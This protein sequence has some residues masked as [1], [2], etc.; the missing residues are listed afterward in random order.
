MRKCGFNVL[1]TSATECIPLR[2][3]IVWSFEMPAVSADDIGTV[4][5]RLLICFIR[6]D[7]AGK[8]G[9]TAAMAAI[10]ALPEKEV[11]IRKKAKWN[12]SPVENV[13]SSLD[14]EN[15]KT[16]GMLKI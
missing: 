11:D 15:S 6:T 2:K 14:L 8:V 5:Y 16:A 9:M 4:T 1:E 13:L 7:P 12:D 10:G 3:S